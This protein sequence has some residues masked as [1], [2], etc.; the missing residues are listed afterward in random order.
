M[1]IADVH[2]LGLERAQ[3]LLLTEAFYW[4]RNEATRAWSRLFLQRRGRMPTMQQA[5]VYSSVLHYLKA[6]RSAGTDDGPT[7]AAQMRAMPVE[8][9]F[10]GH[11]TIRADGRMMHDMLLVQVKA[12]GES[13]QPWDYYRVLRVLPAADVAPPLE[14]SE[15]LAARTR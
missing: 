4:D 6:V 2:A 14:S 11:G 9:F 8:D 7:V 5:G 3:G 12:P 10:A 15:C 1:T 13:D